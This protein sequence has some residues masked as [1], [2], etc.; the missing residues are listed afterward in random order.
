MELH[1]Y[2][3]PTND[4]GIGVHWSPG[5]ANAVGMAKLREQWIPELRVLGVK[6]VKIYNHD[7]AL[8][9]AEALVSEG[10]MPII[11]LY[12]STPN[13]GR[14]GLKELV[15]VDSFL[16]VGARYF[17][18]NSEPDRDSEWRGGRVPANAIDLVAE[19]TIANMEAILER[20]GMP[21]IPALSNGSTWDLVG[22]IVAMGRKDLFNGPVWQAIHNYSSNRPLDYPYDIGNQEGA[23]FTERFYQV[24]SDESWDENA[25]RGRSL[26]EVNRLRLDRC[27]P[28][29]STS[30]DHHC[31]LA[32]E[33][34]DALNRKH[35]GRS[36]PIL[37]TESGF[38]V[39]EDVDPRYPATTP[40]LHMAQTLEACR[41]MMGTSQRYAVAPD[42]Y[43]CTAFWLLGNA[44]LG[45]SSSWLEKHAWYSNQWSA[46]ALPVTRALKAEPKQVRRW[47]QQGQV[48][49]R[50]AVRGFI[51][52]AT[53]NR[54]VMLEKQGS[55]IA[56]TVLDLAGRFSF[57]GLLPGRYT[58]KLLGE[59][60]TQPIELAPGQVEVAVN[61]AVEAKQ[62]VVSRSV[63]TGKVRGGAS[64]VIILVRRSDGEEWVSMA[65]DDGTFRF[66]DLPPGAYSVRVDPEGTR[67]DDIRLDGTNQREV[68][69]AVA[70]WGYTVETASEETGIATFRVIV[71]GNRN[72][73]VTAHSG[74]WSSLPTPLGVNPGLAENE[75]E[76]VGIE[77]GHYIVTLE[78]NA[79]ANNRRVDAEARVHVDKRRVPLV[80]FVHVDQIASIA[81]TR[82]V[83]RGR[84]VGLHNPNE[85]T[86]RLTNELRETRESAL[87][88][89]GYFTFGNLP[90]GRYT[91]ELVGDSE[92]VSRSQIAVDG[93][94]EIECDLAAP[95]STVIGSRESIVTAPLIPESTAHSVI[96]GLAP[97]CAGREARLVDGAGNEQR[98]IVMSDDSVRF[99]GLPPGS[100][101]LLIDGGYQQS[102]IEV[103]GSN[104]V[105]VLFSPLIQTWEVQVSHAGS[106]PGFSA[107][108]VE[109]QGEKD[110]PV[111]IWKDDWDGLMQ[112]TGSRKDLG[113]FA[114]EFSPLGPG[115]YMIEPEGLDIY[116]DVELT[117][118]EA[119]W[120]SFRAVSQTTSPNTLLAL[121][122]TTHQA[123]LVGNLTPAKVLAA[124]G[125]E[126][127]SYPASY[128]YPTPTYDSQP[129]N[130]SVP[131]NAESTKQDSLY[132]WVDNQALSGNSLVALLRYVALHQ[133]VIGTDFQEAKKAKLVVILGDDSY[134]A[135]S[136]CAQLQTKLSD[137]D[138]QTELLSIDELS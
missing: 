37:S 6:W 12:R 38:L 94:N 73:F 97:L 77:P 4:T 9:F 55:E 51:L 20:G 107:V 71:E 43:F 22:K 42:Y 117:G 136:E 2:P 52:N 53:E 54:T 56:R 106:M 7:G 67:V 86:M 27:N 103:D 118:L 93:T 1:E 126:N 78:A 61:L 16:R 95:T 15:T 102:A 5:I 91:V 127:E 26:A 128:E 88:A 89:D 36:L 74:S 45:S 30:D 137:L 10:M 129:T 11:R 46:G 69:L 120:V 35:L 96:A 24:L 3:R 31:F 47:S 75:C 99:S 41:V 105:E 21:G 114:L 28:G 17:E 87:L 138:I 135:Q 98:S 48:G 79:D 33:Y 110:R 83:I 40:N 104:G 68:A 59:E 72:G 25:W 132:L 18:F 108:R 134:F 63:V 57:E 60:L 125:G 92:A 115:I 82:S 23:A 122:V 66:V 133:P 65:G 8:D 123:H 39:G 81:P 14:L 29:M 32:F 131:Y 64:A 121:P 62:R 76:F 124:E 49:E 119:I 112:T 111:R 116:T 58:V 84:V 44:I 113:E 19:D 100:Y 85:R 90:A 13:P 50:V 34:W 101:T 130:H 80:R 109:V 70:G